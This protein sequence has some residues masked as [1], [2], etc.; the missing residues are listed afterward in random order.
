MSRARKPTHAMIDCAVKSGEGPW[1]TDSRYPAKGDYEK[2]FD[3]GKGDRQILLWTIMY[4]ARNKELVPEWA[5]KSLED[6]MY[7]MA[8]GEFETWDDAFGKIFA[9]RKRPKKIRG[10]A[11]MFKVYER[12]LELKKSGEKINNELFARVGKEFGIGTIGA[13]TTIKNLYG[14]AK[15]ELA[16]KGQGQIR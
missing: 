15:H 7:R 14:D 9:F 1:E 6:I 2:R 16:V 11:R 4:S 3:G 5:A 8:E 13:A 10:R 12:V